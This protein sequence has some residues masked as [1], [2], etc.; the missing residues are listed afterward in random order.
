MI[1]HTHK[2]IQWQRVGTCL[3]RLCFLQH[4][5]YT[6][7]SF[8]IK[9]AW[10]LNKKRKSSVGKVFIY[11]LRGSSCESD[12]RTLRRKTISSHTEKKTLSSLSNPAFHLTLHLTDFQSIYKFEWLPSAKLCSGCWGHKD[13]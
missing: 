6:N 10:P 12:N 1:E 13:K 3:T 5:T 9:Y 4:E 11:R 7:E 2:H 8:L